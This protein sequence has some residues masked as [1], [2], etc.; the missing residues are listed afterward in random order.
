M[1]GVRRPHGIF[2]SIYQEVSRDLAFFFNE[3]I[4]IQEIK[5]TILQS[6]DE[7][8]EKILQ[9]I[10]VF[11]IY[12]DEKLKEEKKKSIALNFKLQSQKETLSD[13]KINKTI[14]SIIL[15]IKN[16]LNGILTI[17]AK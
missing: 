11:D 16:E 15:N 2:Q 3:E 8:E 9:Q 5:N 4:T 6:I 13:K 1:P 7:T 14:D 17:E 12:Q 10:N